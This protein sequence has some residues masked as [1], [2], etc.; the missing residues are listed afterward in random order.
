MVT[1]QGNFAHRRASVCRVLSSRVISIA[2]V[3]AVALGC[4][5]T[6]PQTRA[7]AVPQQRNY[8]SVVIEDVPH[9]E[10]KPDFC[11]EAVT[12]MYLRKLGHDVDQDDVFGVTGMDPGRGMGA[13]TRELKV[14]LGRLGFDV[15]RVWYSADARNPARDLEAQFAAMHEDLMRGVPSIVCTHYDDSPDTTEHFRLV[16]GY[17]AD[18]DEVIYHEPA[19]ANASYRRMDRATF[20]ALWPLKYDARSWTV[21]RFP[22]ATDG[23][24]APA[25]ASGHTAADFAQH[26][27]ALKGKAPSGFTIVVEAPFVVIG[28]G[29]A[30]DVHRRAEQTV[31]WAVT[32]L[33][34]DFFD[35]DP[36]RILDIWLF[37]D[38]ASYDKYARELFGDDPGTPYGYYSSSDGAL[39]MNISTGG[40]TLVHE[41]VHPFI[42]ANFPN[43]PAW[44]NEGLGSL[45]EQSSSR[46]GHIVGLTNWRLEGLQDAIDSDA[47]PSFKTLMS[48]TDRQ[49]Y[50][51][52]DGTNYAQ[53]R[54]LLYYMQERGL[55]VDFYRE[56]HRNRRR[57]PTGYETLKSVLGLEDDQ[58][59]AFQ[60]KWQRYV[61]SLTFP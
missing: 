16:L 27:M 10:Q 49:F 39:V 41:I 24:V 11:G 17:D 21:I 22:L 55:L 37:D 46:D 4:K 47:V 26:V 35:R 51:D 58:M 38:A 29:S 32:R 36:D 19:E 23:V 18:S 54:Y 31:R 13:T 25:P 28:N 60:R 56:F 1:A 20:L 45:F 6:E 43:C 59:P 9:V 44:F 3:S 30:Q 61:A 34:G 33:K 14:A 7:P 50:D 15:G 2:V 57:D 48:T 53:A 42:E 40:G 5:G 52:D 8:A 12:E